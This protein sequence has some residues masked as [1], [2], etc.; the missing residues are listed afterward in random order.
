MHSVAVRLIIVCVVH[1]FWS[2]CIL[3]IEVLFICAWFIKVLLSMTLFIVIFHDCTVHH[4]TVHSVIVYCST[5]HSTILFIM[6]CS[7]VFQRR[8]VHKIL[9]CPPQRTR[10][11]LVSLLPVIILRQQM[12]R[13]F[14]HLVDAWIIDFGVIDHIL[15][16]KSQLFSS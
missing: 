1:Y 12:V 8:K 15:I 4:S 14:S 16:F 9:I 3:F 11:F 10:T 2:Q 5:V 13:S 7:A 6:P